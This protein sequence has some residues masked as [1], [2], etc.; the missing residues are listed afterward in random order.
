MNI[1]CFGD[2]LTEGYYNGGKNFS[3]YTQKLKKLL[4]TKGNLQCNVINAGISGET[5]C[6]DMMARLP[7]LLEKYEY[8]DVLV[9]QGGTND[10]LLYKDLQSSIDLFQEFQKLLQI[11]LD[12]SVVKKM[13]ILTTLEGLYTSADEAV[14]PHEV[15][16]DL[17]RKFNEQIL[18]CYNGSNMDTVKKCD[19]PI[20]V[21]DLAR[22]FP[23]FSLNEK[24]RTALWDD[25]IHPSV[26]G[27]DR[28]GEIIFKHLED[29]V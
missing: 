17:R 9:I 27:Y 21:C 1:V 11:A 23:F 20:K 13:L 19:T 16:D 29:I 8:I 7:K 3:P 18:D 10:I 12:G 15:S 22:E 26:L 6:V 24:E 14:M 25:N 28:M 2:S 5:I 4:E